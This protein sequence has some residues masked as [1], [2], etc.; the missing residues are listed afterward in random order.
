MLDNLEKPMTTNIGCKVMKL[1]DQ[2]GEKDGALLLS[3]VDDD[4]W[5]AE[6]LVRALAERGVKIGPMAIRTH[7]KRQ[8]ACRS[9]NA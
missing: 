6:H 9:L 3:Y 5:I 7:R 8:C 2:L 1:A 4:S